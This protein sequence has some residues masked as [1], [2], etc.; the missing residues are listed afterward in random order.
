MKAERL[1]NLQLASP[2]LVFIATWFMSGSLVGVLFITMCAFFSWFSNP[3]QH[4]LHQGPS[5]YAFDQWVVYGLNVN[6]VCGKPHPGTWPP[7]FAA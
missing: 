3:E 5:P 2:T 1:L 6:L 4:I 7:P